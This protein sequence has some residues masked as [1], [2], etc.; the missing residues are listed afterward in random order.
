MHVGLDARA[1]AIVMRTVRNIVNT[2]RTIVCTIHQPSI[3]IFESF[4]ELLLLKRGG[5]TIF[6]G[7]LG[8]H[9]SHLIDYFQVTSHRAL[10]CSNPSSAQY[11][12]P[13]LVCSCCTKSISKAYQAQCKY[14]WLQNSCASL[15]SYLYKGVHAMQC[16]SQLLLWL[17]VCCAAES[18]L[19]ALCSWSWLLCMQGVKGAPA[20]QEGMNPA[21]WMLEVTTPGMESKL[22]VSFA[23]YY[24]SS[25]L[26]K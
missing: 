15:S 20:I 16:S 24:A 2:G 13:L 10:A 22:G 11:S 18:S 6:N 4:D 23:Q 14:T 3:D 9:S 1:A 7:Q 21:T 19:H 5:E 25:D 12:S 8:H 26:A 17:A